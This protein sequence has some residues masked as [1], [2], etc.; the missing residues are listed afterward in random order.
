MLASVYSRQTP[1][2]CHRPEE[3]TATPAGTSSCGTVEIIPRN[4][5]PSCSPP[6]LHPQLL[7]HAKPQQKGAGLQKWSRSVGTCGSPTPE[8]GATG[9]SGLP[10]RGNDRRRFHS[11]ERRRAT[12]PPAGAWPVLS[13]LGFHPVLLSADA[14]SPPLGP[15]LASTPTRTCH[16]PPFRVP[17]PLPVSLSPSSGLNS[18]GS[19]PCP[20]SACSA[21]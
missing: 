4:V 9:Q 21:R 1:R 3:E 7:A 14:G 11:G 20:T 8:W 5:Y 2:P 6:P 15:A 12:R 19:L 13:S 16:T 10:G 17:G 18:P